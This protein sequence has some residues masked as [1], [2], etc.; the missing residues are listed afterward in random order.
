MVILDFLL[1]AGAKKRGGSS[2]DEFDLELTDAVVPVLVFANICLCDAAGSFLFAGYSVVIR[3]GRRIHHNR[4]FW[5]REDIYFG[6]SPVGR[7]APLGGRMTAEPIPAAQYL[8]MS[9][10]HQQ[11]SLDNQADAIALYAEDR[12]FCILRTYCDAAK[13]GLRLKNRPGLRQ[14]LK[15]VVEGNRAFRAVLVYDVSRWGRFQDADEAAHYEF[16][17]KSAGVPVHY[18][19]EAFANDNS[20][21]AFIMKALKRTMAGEYSRDLSARVRAGLVRLAKQGY[22]LGGN[23][24]YGLRRMLLDSKGN[25]KQPLAHGER[26]CIAN[27]LSFSCLDRLKRFRP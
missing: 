26:K 1:A 11:Y 18:C 4:M 17:C 15:D 9:T 23:P 25:P 22:K 6:W 19:A 27:E 20:I 7:C 5:S 16:L 21:P 13:S 10:D 12:G 24:P 3:S 14:L 2:V 8:R